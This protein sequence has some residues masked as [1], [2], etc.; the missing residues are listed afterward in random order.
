MIYR[1]IGRSSIK[2]SLIGYG[3]WQAGGSHWTGANDKDALEAVRFAVEKGINFFDTAPV[4]GFGHSEELLGR[5]LAPFRQNVYIATKVGLVWDN[6]KKISRSL[7]RAS[8]LN[9]IDQ[10]LKR[11]KTDYIDLIQI[12]W[13][14]RKTPIREV[15]ETFSI[16]RQQ[17]K[18]RYFGLCNLD[19]SCITIAAG[20]KQVISIQALYNML[21]PNPAFFLNEKLQYRTEEQLLDLCREKKLSLIPYSP[22]AQGLLTDSF[23]P[24]TLDPGD[25]RLLDKNL[26]EKMETRKEL[27]GQAAAR[28]ISLNAMAIRFLAGQTLIPTIIIGTTNKNHIAQNIEALKQFS[29]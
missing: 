24:D 2:S 5:A 22:L 14:D 6:N 26:K 13:N 27:L 11:L 23:S 15:M 4:Y 17:G 12:H 1:T 10:S 29:R 19:P 28:G 7:E 8:I 20:N 25:I 21:T 9:E 18:V 16:A 3:A